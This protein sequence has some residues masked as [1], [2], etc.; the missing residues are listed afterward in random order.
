MSQTDCPTETPD[1]A[2]VI[3]DAINEH[4]DGDGFR[5][6]ILD[7]LEADEEN[8]VAM[9]GEAILGIEVTADL[10]SYEEGDGWNEPRYTYYAGTFIVW[11]GNKQIATGT[12]HPEDAPEFDKDF[13]L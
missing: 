1:I 4:I 7:I 5:L 3:L 2:E 12:I 6:D 11:R 9:Y 13:S 10:Y 8:A